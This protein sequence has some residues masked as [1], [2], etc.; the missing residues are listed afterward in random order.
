M[1]SVRRPRRRE[2]P[3]VVRRQPRRVRPVGVHHVDVAVPGAVILVRDLRAVRA[4]VR[5][6]VVRAVVGR[7]LRLTAPVRVHDVHLLGAGAIAC[8]R[9]LRAVR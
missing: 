3:S 8:E 7:E 9:D 2:L 4:P 6:L 1:A 5:H